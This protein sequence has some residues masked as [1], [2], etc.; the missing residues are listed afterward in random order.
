MRTKRP[1]LLAEDNEVDAETVRRAL[2]V[3]NRQGLRPLKRGLK[4][5]LRFPWFQ[6]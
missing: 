2:R 4:S 3:F 1:M 6:G 5:A